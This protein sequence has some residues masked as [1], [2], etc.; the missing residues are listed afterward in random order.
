MELT[1]E[2]RTLSSVGPFTDRGA[3]QMKGLDFGR[4]IPTMGAAMTRVTGM[5]R[6][7]AR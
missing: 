4:V 3:T 2:A 5:I 1:V 7:R 6:V